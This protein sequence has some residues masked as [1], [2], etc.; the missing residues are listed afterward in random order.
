[1]S[2][3]ARELLGQ[4]RLPGHNVDLAPP[5]EW[6]TVAEA[7]ERYGD[8]TPGPDPE[9]ER[10]FHTLVDRIEP[11]LGRSRPTILCEYPASQAALS[12]LDPDNPAVALRFEVYVEGIELANAF[13]E[14]TDSA[15]QRQRFEEDLDERQRLDKPLLPIDEGLLAA[16]AN[17]PPT[18]GAAM[19]VDRL[20]MLLTGSDDVESVVAFPEPWL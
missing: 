1:V 20:V 16:V 10:F 14:L 15:Q 4:T 13:D 8:W 19:G 6:L 12:R 5:W 3:L 11:K 2:S 17:M 7:F 9:P 18:T